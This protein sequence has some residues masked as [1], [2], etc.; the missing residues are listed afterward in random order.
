MDGRRGARAIEL[1]LEHRDLGVD[2]VGAG[3]DAGLVAFVDDPA[4]FERRAETLAGRVDTGPRRREVER[5][6]LQFESRLPVELGD[7]GFNRA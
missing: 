3:R 7:A 1:G 5:P 6:G 4:G 2:H